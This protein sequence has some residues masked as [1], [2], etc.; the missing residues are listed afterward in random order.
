MKLHLPE[1]SSISSTA[2]QVSGQQYRLTAN[3]PGWAGCHFTFSEQSCELTFIHETG[4]PKVVCSM[5]DWH[6]GPDPFFGLP[7]ACGAVWADPSTC[8]IHI[9]LLEQQQMFILTCRFD[10]DGLVLQIKP[11]G[12]LRTNHLDLVLIGTKMDSP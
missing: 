12:A 2:V 10:R 5:N 7:S 9:Q 4:R 1:G 6:I 3:E 8:L 11:A